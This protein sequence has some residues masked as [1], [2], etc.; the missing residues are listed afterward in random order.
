MQIQQKCKYWYIMNF[1]MVHSDFSVKLD[2]NSVPLYC[3]RRLRSGTFW[4]PWQV[5]HNFDRVFAGDCDAHLRAEQ[6][7]L[8]SCLLQFNICVP[9][10][11]CVLD[12]GFST[13]RNSVS[14]KCMKQAQQLTSGPNLHGP[15]YCPLIGHNPELL[16]TCLL[17]M[18]PWE[19]ICV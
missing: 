19:D 13:Q 1:I 6:L 18:T 4:S 7:S 12:T 8:S 2:G 11:R 5:L 17:D 9:L 3:P 10:L 15:D 16:L 14:T